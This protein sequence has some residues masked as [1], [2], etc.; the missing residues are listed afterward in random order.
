[1]LRD[2]VLSRTAGSF[3]MLQHN[4]NRNKTRENT[5]INLFLNIAFNFG[6][7]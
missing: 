7:R 5:E 4:G 3:I 1:M 2:S 6:T